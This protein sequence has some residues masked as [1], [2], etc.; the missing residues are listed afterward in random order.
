MGNTHFEPKG[1]YKY[2][3]MARSQDGVLS[4]EHERYAADE[5]G[6]CAMCGI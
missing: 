1:F 2:T 5:E 3:R 6:C 4:N